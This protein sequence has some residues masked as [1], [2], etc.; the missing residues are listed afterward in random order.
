VKENSWIVAPEIFAF[1][2]LLALLAH[3][4]PSTQKCFQL[5]LNGSVIR[6]FLGIISLFLS[7]VFSMS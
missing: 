6:G 2:A 3:K 7:F 4:G 1:S 5:P